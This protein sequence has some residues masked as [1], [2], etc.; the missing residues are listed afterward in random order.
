MSVAT[1]SLRDELEAIHRQVRRNFV[2]RP[3]I[4]ERWDMPP[5]DY[6]GEQTLRDD[7]DGFCLACRQLLRQRNIPSRL[8]YCEIDGGGHLVVEVQGWILDIL[9]RS[10]VSNRAIRHYRWLRMS[11]YEVGEPWR[12]IVAV[13]E[14]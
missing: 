14:A 7:C 2:S 13:A 9:Q 8:V 1:R 11:G 3:D 10:V 5:L 4:G 6:S 12:E